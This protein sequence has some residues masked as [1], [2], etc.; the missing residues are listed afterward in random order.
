MGV[1]YQIAADP[2]VYLFNYDKKISVRKYIIDG[3]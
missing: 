3:L 1:W 2:F